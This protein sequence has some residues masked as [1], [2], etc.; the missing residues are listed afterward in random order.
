MKLCLF[1]WLYGLS[2]PING[3]SLALGTSHAPLALPH[4]YAMQKI[5]SR[6]FFFNI[7][8]FSCSIQA[9][10]FTQGL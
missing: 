1:L 8:L 6:L 7:Y 3:C 5:A 2:V 10:H 4:P 9:L